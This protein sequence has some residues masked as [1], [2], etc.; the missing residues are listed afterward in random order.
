MRQRFGRASTHLRNVE[1]KNEVITFGFF[2]GSLEELRAHSGLA[3]TANDGRRRTHTSSRRWSMA[4]TNCWLS[5]P[6]DEREYPALPSSA[7]NLT[8]PD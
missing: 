8:P 5:V 6:L 1:D 4:Y 3:A 2:G 7:H